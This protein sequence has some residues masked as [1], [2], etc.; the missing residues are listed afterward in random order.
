MTESTIHLSPPNAG[1][2]A[3]ES[4]F[5]RPA[6]KPIHLRPALANPAYVDGDGSAADHLARW[7]SL[8]S[9]SGLSESDQQ[10]VTNAVRRIAIEGSLACGS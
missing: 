4:I 2:C 10:P 6:W 5:A 7:L 3:V 1:E 8:P 9:G